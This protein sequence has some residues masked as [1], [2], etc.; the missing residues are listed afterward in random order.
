MK[1]EL[2]QMTEDEAKKLMQ[3]M[4]DRS[5]KLFKEKLAQGIPFTEELI[6]EVSDQALVESINEFNADNETTSLDG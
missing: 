1:R 3:D 4:Q 5:T 6:Q 2:R